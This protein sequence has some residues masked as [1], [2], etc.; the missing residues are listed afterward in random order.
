MVVK[1]NEVFRAPAVIIATGAGWRQLGV[2]GETE[3]IGRGV[4][5]CPHCD[6]PFY[7]G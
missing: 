2:K 3:Y 1:G 7:A 6:G 4:A 5:F